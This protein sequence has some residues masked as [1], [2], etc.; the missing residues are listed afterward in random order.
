MFVIARSTLR[1]EAETPTG[2]L[3]DGGDMSV[4]VLP[5]NSPDATREVAGGKGAGLSSLLRGGFPV[6]LGFVITTEAYRAFVAGASLQDDIARHASASS[7]EAIDV[8]SATLRAR[9]H[10]APVPPQLAHEIAAAYSWLAAQVAEAE[11]ADA[12]PL[13]VSTRRRR[14]AASSRSGYPTTWSP[15]RSWRWMRSRSR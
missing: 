10:A 7:P 4:F 15:R 3:A 2:L 13:V 12:L 8:A 11:V 1:A 9:I 5:L 6:P 14:C